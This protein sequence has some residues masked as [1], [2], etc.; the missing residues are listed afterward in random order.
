LALVLNIS[1]ER[2][3]FNM[4]QF[5]I[6][7]FNIIIFLIVGTFVQC[8]SSQNM[9]IDKNAPIGIKD[10]YFQEWVAGI[11]GGGSGFTVYIPVEESADVTLNYTYF[12]GKKIEL[13]LSNNVYIGR[14]TYPNKNTDLIMSDDPKEEFKNKLPEVEKNI[15]FELEGNACVVGY[16]KGTENGF[17][18]IE[19]VTEK[20]VKALPMRRRQ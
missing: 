7:S 16:T 1:N 10:P 20:K 6:F 5:K 14:Y 8:A 2:K 13:K 4:T 3:S 17:F 9:E 11:K 15:P 12:K 18:K 19:N